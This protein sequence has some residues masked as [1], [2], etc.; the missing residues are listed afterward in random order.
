M[1]VER[2]R[3]GQ[4]FLF[5]GILLLVIFFSTEPGAPPLVGFFLSGIGLAILGLYMI[6][7]AWKPPPPSGRFRFLRR[8]LR[9][10]KDKQYD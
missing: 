5:V 7:R 10:P 4:F 9:R 3:V 8:L 2:G 1:H 6:R